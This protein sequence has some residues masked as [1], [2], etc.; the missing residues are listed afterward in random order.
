MSRAPG[1]GVRLLCCG[2]EQK[3]LQW[4]KWGVPD[5]GASHG[6][7]GANSGFSCSLRMGKTTDLTRL[8]LTAGLQGRKVPHFLPQLLEQSLSV[9]LNLA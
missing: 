2:L 6:L 3:Q 4:E 7:P 9:L 8:S 5:P 1:S